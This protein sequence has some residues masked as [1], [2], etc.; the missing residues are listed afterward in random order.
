MKSTQRVRRDRAG[1][2]LI[3]LLV[4]IAIVGIL[5]QIVVPPMGGVLRSWRSKQAADQI[6]ADF[7]YARALAIQSVSG[8][9]IVF[10]SE[11]RYRIDQGVG[12]GATVQ[13]TVDL[14]REYGPVRLV[15]PSGVTE[16]RFNTRGM[17]ITGAGQFVV[18]S[19]SAGSMRRDTFW[20]S[21][22]GMVRREG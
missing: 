16:I 13:K 10:L 20:V 18:E 4:A 1:F 3:E 19:E 11:Q 7:S 14:G 2:T 9:K 17:A 15:P 22:L 6:A 8:A 21:T 12:T 5:A